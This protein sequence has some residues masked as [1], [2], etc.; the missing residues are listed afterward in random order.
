MREKQLCRHQGQW[1][2]RRR[3]RCSRHQSRDSP[4]ARDEDH[5]EAGCPP[6]AH[7]DPWWS[8]YPPAAQG[9]PTQEDAWSRLWPLGELALEQ[10][11]GRSCGPMER[12]AHPGAGLLAG[13]VTLWGAHAGAAC[14]WRTAPHGKDPRWSSSW[15]TVSCGRDLT[16]EQGR[17]VRSPPPEEEEVAETTCDALTVTPIP[18]P[19]APLRGRRQRNSR[20]K[21]GVGGRCFKIWFCFSLSYSD[22]IG[23]KL[24]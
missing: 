3:R 20:K 19:P 10:A 18:H 5:G 11:S 1:R 6:A 7:G 14:S 17:S 22:L 24:N 15:R 13:L 2:R 4:A 9:G 23:D 12:G 8:R 21:G 16:L